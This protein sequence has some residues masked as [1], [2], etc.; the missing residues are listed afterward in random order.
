MKK[1][2]LENDDQLKDVL[3]IDKTAD[4]DSSDFKVSEQE[5]RSQ[6]ESED[7]ALIDIENDKM[8]TP[9]TMRDVRCL[10]FQFMYAMEQFDYSVSFESVIDN[11][12]RGFNLEIPDDFIAIKIAR[13][14][15]AKREELDAKITPLLK[16]WKIDRL[17]CCTLLILRLA[18]WEFE[19]NKD[20]SAAIIIN[21]AIELA[22]SFGEKNS[23][24]FING[25]LDEA[26]K[27]L[28]LPNTKTEKVNASGE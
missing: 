7:Q 6:I 12:R 28:N 26:I 22:K 18:M 5:L 14:T 8:R 20:T 4:S 17:G 27:S 1:N 21:E 3:K 24:K 16:N 25:I 15:I 2:V 9:K 10:I 19:N 11:F 13:D 23:Y